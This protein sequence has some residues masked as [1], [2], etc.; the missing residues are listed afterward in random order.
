MPN[1]FDSSV[2]NGIL[3]GTVN[4]APTDQFGVVAA[5]N[6]ISETLN[7]DSVNPIFWMQPDLQGIILGTQAG[8]YLV[9]APTNGPMSPTNIAARRVTKI[10]C[11]N[12][13]PRR[14]EHTNVFVQ[15]Y[16][17]KLMEYFADVYS[18]KFSAPN[19]ADK[20][21]HITRVGIAELAYQQAVTPIIWGRG[22]DG[23]LF[24]VTYKRDTLTTAQ[25][26]TFNGWHRHALGSGR[27]VESICVGPSIGGNLDTLTMVTT[28]SVTG[29]RHVEV[30]TDSFDES[31]PLIDAWF[32]DDAVTPTS[33]ISTSTASAGAPYGGLTLNGLWHLNGKVVSVFAAGL[34]CGD[35]LVTGGSCFV[36]YGDGVSAG[37]GGGLFT[38]AYV[39]SIAPFPIVVGFTYN[40]DGQMVRPILVADTGARLGP[41]L[42]D[43]RRNHRYSM[44]L[45]NTLG[46]SVCGSSFA[47]LK[48][49]LFRQENGNAIPP[50][51]TFSGVHQDSL[52][53]DYTYDGMIT[54]RVSRPY[55]ANVI[56]ISGNI[57]TKDQ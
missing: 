42:G 44:L 10:G 21:Q 52:V 29:T 11:A 55:P 25:G 49:A 56:A 20:A 36:P 50:L 57:S 22:A 39:S 32:L 18:G 3:G 1:R 27:I 43:L 51:T 4:F 5:N 13:E 2:S 40:S 54:W 46:L 16:S 24:G 26:P 12:V 30:L 15:R 45:D 9:Q 41:A 35:F 31:S 48:P 33:T 19:I 38:A 23:S 17:Q 7:S 28:D 34:D 37:T 47:N 8:E 53:D 14:T 6:G